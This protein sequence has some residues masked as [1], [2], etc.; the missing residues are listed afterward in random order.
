MARNDR[1]TIGELARAAGVPTTTVRYYERIGLLEPEA[2]SSGN[3]RLY[4]SG[5]L[6]RLRFVRA[7]HAVGFTLEDVRVLLGTGD[8]GPPSCPEVQTLIGDRLEE[9]E[10]RLDDLRHVRKVLRESLARC[11]ATERDGC[12]HVIETLDAASSGR[13]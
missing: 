11:T 8:E 3:Y 1:F 10:R 9:I 2:R 7:A 12:C 6:R 4:S 13:G 5:S